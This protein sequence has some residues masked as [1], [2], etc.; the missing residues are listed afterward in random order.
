MP[1]VGNALSGFNGYGG[2][3]GYGLVNTLPQV[4][5]IPS[6]MDDWDLEFERL[7][8]ALPEF[9]PVHQQRRRLADWHKQ[10]A[11]LQNQPRVGYTHEW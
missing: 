5:E 1:G 7:T 9:S 10:Q 8:G 6:E 4:V 11:G 3:S 2:L